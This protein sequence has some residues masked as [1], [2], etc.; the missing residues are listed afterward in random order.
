MDQPNPGPSQPVPVVTAIA[1]AAAA[2]AGYLPARRAA[3]IDPIAALRE[4]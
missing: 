2:V 3:R 1:L 4:N